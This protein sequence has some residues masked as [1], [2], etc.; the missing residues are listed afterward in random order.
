MKDDLPGPSMDT[1]NS[2]PLPRWRATAGV[3]TALSDAWLWI[4]IGV[5]TAFV[6][7]GQ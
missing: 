7:F 5:A 1:A 6:A 3:T 4:V 2:A